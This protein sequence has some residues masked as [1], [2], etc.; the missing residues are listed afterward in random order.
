MSIF[1]SIY[2]DEI[3]CTSIS[4]TCYFDKSCSRVQKKFQE[5]N[6]KLFDFQDQVYHIIIDTTET[7]ISGSE[8]GSSADRC[9]VPVF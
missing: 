9:Y 1:K 6:I 7:F 3:I 4:G 8:V 5:I 2:G